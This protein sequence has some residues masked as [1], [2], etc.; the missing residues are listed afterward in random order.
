VAAGEDSAGILLF[1]LVEAIP[2]KANRWK[3]I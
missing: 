2:Q 1:H 3:F